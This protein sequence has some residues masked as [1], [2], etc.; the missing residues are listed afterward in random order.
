MNNKLSFITMLVTIILFLIAVVATGGAVLVMA[1]FCALYIAA[2]VLVILAHVKQ[3]PKLML[4]AAILFILTYVLGGVLAL[5]YAIVISTPSMVLAFVSRS[6][7]K[8]EV[9]LVTSAA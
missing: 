1:R 7:M 3:S 6:K 4:I 5:A 9:I 8:K 2:M